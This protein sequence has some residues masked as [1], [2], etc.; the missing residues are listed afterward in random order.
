MEPY[1][2]DVAVITGGA[3][4]MGLATAQILG[5]DH[6]ILLSDVKE[7]R[8]DRAV[9]DLRV[10]GIDCHGAVCDVADRESVRKLDERAPGLGRVTSVVHT[11]G[12]SPRMGSARRILDVNA[13]GTAY[14]V[15]AFMALAKEGFALVN[16]ASSAGHMSGPKPKR[17]FA[18][19]ESDPDHMARR[20][21]SICRA[22]PG[23]HRPDVAYMLSKSFVI[24]CSRDRAETFGARGA[25]ILSVSPGSIDT[26]MGRLEADSGS[27]EL[28]ARC[29]G[30]IRPDQR[31]R[32]D[33]G[34]LR[35]RQTRL[36]DRRRHPGRR[37]RRR[38]DD[39]PRHLGNGAPGPLTANGTDRGLPVDR[40]GVSS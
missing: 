40:P 39:H 35:R 16:V 17:T 5:G 18:L 14:V 1:M 2:T 36:P 8:L 34:I 25:R 37:R 11:A 21:H 19:A 22:L 28:A 15:D 3:G 7:G 23:K 33:P 29:A 6:T 38:K 9:E 24:W 20:L 30:P 32:R 4:G 13:V 26:E 12:L 10:L 27:R 31:D